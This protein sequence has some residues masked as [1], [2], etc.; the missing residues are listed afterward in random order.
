[1]GFTVIDNFSFRHFDNFVGYVSDALTLGYTKRV[2]GFSEYPE[3]SF[4]MALYIDDEENNV[5][6]HQDILGE[7]IDFP[8]KNW[9]LPIQRHGGNIRE[10]KRLDRGTNI[11]S[12]SESF[13]DVDGVYTYDRDVLL[14][15]NYADCIPVYVWSEVDDFIG[16]AHAGWRGTQAEITKKLIAAYRGN[17][18]NLRVVIGPGINKDH[19]EVDDKV[20]DALSPLSTASYSQTSTGYLLDLKNVNKE[21]AE[22][23]GIDSNHIHV[24]DFGTEEA[25]FFS[26]RLEKGK[27]GRALAFI[28]RKSK[29]D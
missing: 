6:R 21:Q 28:G 8:V 27:T 3:K 13:Y 29:D 7:K 4:N 19:Y 5:H 1:M 17:I 14:T 11:R 9:V 24:T 22:R 18:E 16:L 10:V 2:D 26:Y 23:V 20:I 25:D 15:M 12:L